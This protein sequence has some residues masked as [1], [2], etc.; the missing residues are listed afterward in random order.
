[1]LWPAGAVVIFVLAAMAPAAQ[2]RGGPGSTL[3][4]M[5]TSSVRGANRLL[6]VR[7]TLT[8]A[9]RAGAN[10]VAFQGSISRLRRLAPGSYVVTVT[11]TNASG[12]S[13]AAHRLSFTVVR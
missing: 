5:A 11:A 6:L 4:F 1:M 9:A 10:T 2:A 8:G 13:S 7:G 12:R 3:R